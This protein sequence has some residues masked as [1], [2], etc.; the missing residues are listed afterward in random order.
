MVLFFTLLLILFGSL[1]DAFNCP[2]GQFIVLTDPTKTECFDTI[3]DHVTVTF[4]VCKKVSLTN[5]ECVY[6]FP[7]N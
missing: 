6:T 2:E 5:S 4:A 3:N 7:T 1:A